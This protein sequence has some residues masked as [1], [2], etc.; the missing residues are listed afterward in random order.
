MSLEEFVRLLSDAGL[1]NEHFG[2]RE[3]GPLWNLSMMTNKDETL[4]DKHL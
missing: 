4:S 1:I 2:I 3:A